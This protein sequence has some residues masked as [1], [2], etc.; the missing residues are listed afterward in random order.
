VLAILIPLTIA[1]QQPA[2]AP[3][4]STDVL[5]DLI[6][7]AAETN[8]RVPRGLAS[9]TA[10]VETEAALVS[11]DSRQREQSV[12]VE[13]IAQS[14]SWD[15][16]GRVDQRVIGYRSQASVF[17]GLTTL[18][19]PTW[20]VPV[21]YGNRF[22]LL[23]GSRE[24][25][26]ASRDSTP[27]T[28]RVDA[29]HPLAA[30][31]DEVYRFSGGDTVAVVRPGARSIPVVRVHVE[32]AVTPA[33][34]TTVLRGEI[35][36]EAATH[37]L[38]AMRGEILEIGG[39]V[40][41]LARAGRQLIQA[42]AYV[43]FQSQ[44][45]EQRYWLP[46]TQRIE[47]QIASPLAGDA[48][49]VWRFQSRFD[50]IAI[51]QTDTALPPTDADTLGALPRRRIIA[52]DA[53]LSAYDRWRWGIGEGTAELRADDFGDIIDNP[54]DRD[55]VRITTGLYARQFDDVLRFNRVE[56]LFTGI[57][58]RARA[59]TS[60]RSLSLGATIG[61]AWHEGTV[62]GG[63]FGEWD[64]SGWALSAA[65]ER[66]LEIA[67]RF[68]DTRLLGSSGTI[69][70]LFG[71]DDFDYLDRRHLIANLERDLLAGAARLGVEAGI[72][73]DAG[74]STTVSQG[75]FR[76]DSAFRPNRPVD[77]GSYARV[78][79]S[80]VMHPDVYAEWTR[81]GWTAGLRFEQG[82]GELSW[83]RIE[84][85]A[86]A[87]RTFGR[88][89]TT[90]RVD[91]GLIESGRIPLQQLF[92]IGGA[93]DVPGFEYKEFGGDRAVVARA[94]VRYALPIFEAPLRFPFGRT[95]QRLPP[96]A[97][98]LAVGL[99]GVWTDASSRATFNA[100]TRLGA[101]SEAG[102][103]LSRPTD[104]MPAAASAGVLLFGGGLF[105]GVSRRLD[106][107][108]RWSFT[109]APSLAL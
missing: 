36:I 6:R 64:A 99:R 103:L 35:L 43:D 46:A 3:T 101:R 104:G 40:S 89:T 87:R 10:T 32:P 105:I 49:A 78:G 45:V 16:R 39:P 75:L 25:T 98:T 60:Q 17:T 106:R 47:L 14:I 108:A 73:S 74:M 90:G 85:G 2:T 41:L 66:R 34:R 1:I 7:A 94:S 100:L 86:A 109:F 63:V 97:P 44:E 83:M 8:I 24:R 93:T 11:V 88:L 67:N 61:R 79:L 53:E 57:G 71:S 22:S 12:Q 51:V 18:T 95:R 54:S 102:M 5:R 13:Q 20:I 4:Y 30:D 27:T 37:H 48:R 96:L 23:F 59:S 28:R 31:R 81:P 72:G 50:D 69:A 70:A 38:I 19:V 9:Y 15:R 107:A 52:G 21:L 58:A 26:R 92:A 42:V 80:M 56:G 29:V 33:V 55:G 62:R 76:V 65:G 77:R 68:G 82:A 91:A 84:T